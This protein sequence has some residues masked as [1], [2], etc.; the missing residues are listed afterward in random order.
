LDPPEST[1][2]GGLRKL[3][4]TN[5]G[6]KPLTRLAITKDGNA[7]ADFFVKALPR[8]PLAPRRSITIDLVFRPKAAGPREAFLH[9]VS[10]GARENPFDLA[11]SGRGVR[12][13][14]K[15]Q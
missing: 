8:K 10:K 14:N 1:I 13:D 7:A 12:G 9:I 6:T 5:T 15:H 2:R 3:T 4:I 11:L